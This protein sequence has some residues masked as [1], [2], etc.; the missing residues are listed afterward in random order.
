MHRH[1]IG[2]LRT[3][4]GVAATVLGCA[5]A[6]AFAGLPIQPGM[7]ELRAATTLNKKAETPEGTKEC[8]SQSDLDQGNR[9]LPKPDGNCTLSNITTSGNRLSYDIAC[10]RDDVTSKGRMELVVT[11]ES[12][13]GMAD[14]VLSAP[15]KSDTPMNVM[16]NARRVGDCAK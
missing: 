8:I 2:F 13:D 16:I 3:G 12:Y 10:Q 7:W 15:G 5:A 1:C 6:S 11:R 14:F 4:L 9:T